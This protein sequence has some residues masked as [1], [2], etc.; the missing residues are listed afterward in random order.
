MRTDDR[1]GA[2]TPASRR[3]SSK[4][5]RDELRRLSAPKDGA[6]ITI[7]LDEVSALSTKQTNAS[8]GQP[9]GKCSKRTISADN[10]QF[11]TA[12][13]RGCTRNPPIVTNGKGRR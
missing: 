3:V 1:S 7:A 9:G 11:S 2:W 13:R 4:L 12:V 6:P 10:D 5:V 8:S